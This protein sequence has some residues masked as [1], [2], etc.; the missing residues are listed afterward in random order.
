VETCQ[1]TFHPTLAGDLTDHHVR[2]GVL[3][4]RN[5]VTLG[6]NLDPDTSYT[7]TFLGFSQVFQ[8]NASVCHPIEPRQLIF[9]YI[10]I[11]HSLIILSYN[12]V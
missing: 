4:L 6:A 7:K 11:H 1:L 2:M 8:E 12:A 5:R 9:A 10:P 3:L